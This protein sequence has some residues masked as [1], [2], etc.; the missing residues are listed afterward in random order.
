MKV[1]EFFW[2]DFS[3]GRCSRQQRQTSWDVVDVA[4]VWRESAD[5][6]ARREKRHERIKEK[7]VGERPRRLLGQPQRG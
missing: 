4:R 3:Q 7:A 1:N 5:V 6:R 2:L